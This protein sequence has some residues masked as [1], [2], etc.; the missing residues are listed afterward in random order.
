MGGYLGENSQSFKACFMNIFHPDYKCQHTGIPAVGRV[1]LA[2]TH[3][4]LS[5]VYKISRK[6]H[7]DISVLGGDL[8]I[9]VALRPTRMG[10]S[11]TSVS[12]KINFVNLCWEK[13]LATCP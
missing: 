13:A 4:Y 6:L 3:S 10:R 8:V 7:R 1:F 5:I 2:S 12:R 9:S 11:R